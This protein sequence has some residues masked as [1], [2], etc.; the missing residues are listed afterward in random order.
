MKLKNGVQMNA[1]FRL[2]VMSNMEC[3]HRLS[4]KE[5]WRSL[6]LL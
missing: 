3:L 6:S 4:E 2:V 5:Q 1:I